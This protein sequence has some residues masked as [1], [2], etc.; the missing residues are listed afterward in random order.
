MD[1]GCERGIICLVGDFQSGKTTLIKHLLADKLDAPEAYYVNLNLYLLQEL[2]KHSA[3]IN[4][5][6]A[7]AKIHLLMQIAVE[8]LLNRHFQTHAL[9]VLDAIE[10]VYPYE[11]NLVA[12]ANRCVP[13]GKQCI[14][15]AP[16]NT[17]QGY[18]FAFSWGLAEIVR[19]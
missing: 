17:Q 14:I 11:L 10:A 12:I 15:C 2:E 19:I 4:Y 8:D 6:G 9:L 16:E 1:Y 5:A 3:A 18:R 13:D 7:K